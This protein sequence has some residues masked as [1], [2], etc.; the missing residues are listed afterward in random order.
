MAYQNTAAEFRPE[1]QA[2]VEE[3]MAID[4]KFISDLLFP[5]FSGKTRT[6]FYKKIRRG[7]GQLLRNPGNVDPTKDPLLRA[8][9][10]AYPEMTRTSEQASW[11]TKDRGIEEPMDDVIKQ[12]ESR[13]Y[14]Q[15]VATSIWLMRNIR[16]ARE[17][18]VSALVMNENIWGKIDGSGDYIAANRDTINFAEDLKAARLVIEKRQEDFNTLVISRAMWDLVTGS[19]LLREYFFGAN[20]GNA[21]ID[22]QMVAQKFE[23]EQILI[24]RASYDTTKPGKDSTDS[25]LVWAWPDN[26]FWVGNV[27]GGPPENGGA[28]RTF[29]L[30]DLTGG[31]LF[32]TETYREERIRSDRLRVRQDSDENTV[33]E[34]SGILVK[35]QNL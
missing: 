21:M 32:V 7:K 27:Q 28:G 2:K 22:T 3:A 31:Q 33:N 18:R 15:E 9:G 6:G 11:S 23:L 30:E 8:P 26:Y 20:G 34:N 4:K 13:F 35:I 14:D 29:I 25:N 12:E 19:A 17:A 1:L 24:G 5:T 10:T 16:I